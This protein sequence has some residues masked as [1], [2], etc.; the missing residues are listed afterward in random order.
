LRSTG[1]MNPILDHMQLQGI[2]PTVR[3]FISLNW[4]LGGHYRT[5]RDLE[6]A[7]LVEDL[8][9]IANMVCSGELIDSKNEFPQES[10]EF[11]EELGGE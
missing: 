2:T 3:N 6:K 7:E 10:A 1:G 11:L 9:A 8:A 4:G 5:V